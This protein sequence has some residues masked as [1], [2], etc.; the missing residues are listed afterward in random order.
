MLKLFILTFVAISGLLTSG[1]TAYAL[2]TKANQLAAMEAQLTE[3][4]VHYGMIESKNDN[5]GVTL[6]GLRKKYSRLIKEAK[7]LEEEEG[8]VPAEKRRIL[9]RMEF[10]QLMVGMIAELKDGHVNNAR[11][12]HDASLVGLYTATIDGHLYV[13]E[14]NKDL[15]PVSNFG[16]RT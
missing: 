2:E 10:Q 16:R 5:Y 6:T 8:F 3:L 11:L 4:E 12:T 1:Y 13:I 9:T 15:C 14:K 7:T